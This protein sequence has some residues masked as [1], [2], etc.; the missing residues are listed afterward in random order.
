MY[1]VHYAK[2]KFKTGNNFDELWEKEKRV[3][4]NRERG[5]RKGKQ[6]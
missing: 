4:T 5:R 1:S 3:N 2:Q 6:E